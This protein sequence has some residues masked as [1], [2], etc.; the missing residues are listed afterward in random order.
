[1]EIMETPME[2]IRRNSHLDSSNKKSRLR[3]KLSK[4]NI[5]ITSSI[6]MLKINKG[7]L[8]KTKNTSNYQKP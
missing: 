6:S 2:I 5:I 4:N 3:G 8:T 1:M 7:T